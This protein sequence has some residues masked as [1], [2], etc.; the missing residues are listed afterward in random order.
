MYEHIWNGKELIERFYGETNG[1]EFKASSL[2][3]QEDPR[4]DLITDSIVDFS[5]CDSVSIPP[6]IIEEVA[7]IDFAASRSNPRIRGAVISDNPDVILG[8]Q[9]YTNL[10]LSPYPVRVFKSIADAREWFAST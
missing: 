2:K 5:A 4:Y 8:V 3:V 6:H 10:G 1:E 9:I 7:A